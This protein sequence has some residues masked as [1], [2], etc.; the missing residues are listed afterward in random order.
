M[1]VNAKQLRRWFSVVSAI[2]V[3]LGAVFAFYGLGILP[4]RREVLWPWTNAVYGATFMG[5]GATLFFVGRL[6]FRRHDPEL[7]KCLLYGLI[8]WF[9]VESGFSA[10]LGVWFNVGVDVAVLAVLSLPLIVGIRSLNKG[11]P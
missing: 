2:M 11:K 8:V 5:W 9:P 6:A 1:A 4:T 3:M 7:M 10:Y